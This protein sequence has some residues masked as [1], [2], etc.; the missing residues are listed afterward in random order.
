[1]I[2]LI[3][4][5]IFI[6]SNHLI[7]DVN[8]DWINNL[9]IIDAIVHRPKVNNPWIMNDVRVKGFYGIFINKNEILTSA[10][11]V[12]AS[13][14]LFMQKIGNT[15]IFELKIS[16]INKEFDLAILKLK[17]EKKL[18]NFKN[19]KKIKFAE[20]SK[21]D[22]LFVINIKN[23]S[24]IKKH[25]VKFQNL[26]LLT[27]SFGSL[28]PMSIGIEKYPLTRYLLETQFKNLG[29]AEIVVDDKNRLIG[30]ITNMLKNGNAVVTPIE[31][32][33]NFIK[34]NNPAYTL[35]LRFNTILDDK[36]K[37]LIGLKEKDLG[38]RLV[39][40][41]KGYPKGILKKDDILIAIVLDNKKFYID[42]YGKYID[43]LYG[44]V[45]YRFLINKSISNN[46]EFIF[47]RNGKK[48]QLK[49]KLYPFDGD[50]YLIPFSRLYKNNKDIDYVFFGGL[51]FQELTQNFSFVIYKNIY[52]Q[53]YY[54]LD[55][56]NLKR[57]IILSNMIKN[58]FNLGYSGFVFSILKNINGY[59]I[60]SLKDLRYALNKT[61]TVKNGKKYHIFNF[62][63][64][65][66]SDMNEYLILEK[67]SEKLKK[68]HNLF[69]RENSMP[70]KVN[71]FNYANNNSK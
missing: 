51:V 53:N 48:F 28:Q 30:I 27:V 68:V 18:I 59:P 56:N 33:N 41:A 24:S 44:K 65:P 8:K 16:K 52:H 22:K 49:L 63:I 17:D 15:E 46:M 21:S 29:Y 32:I 26:D 3:L 5:I 12:Y 58:D 20:N 66:D 62:S 6:F 31:I 1:M 2:N 23:M 39:E 10:S 69:A 4:S 42:N 13:K 34:Y 11:A 14:K 55:K 37:K 54:Q 64:T 9:V 40:I 47:I 45:D 7:A 25:L 61:Q 57:I 60:H 50:N 71:F 35:G 36:F 70:N 19:I 43:P 67:S 38:I